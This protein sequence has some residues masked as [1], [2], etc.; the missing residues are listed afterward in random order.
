MELGRQLPPAAQD[1]FLFSI[2]ID[3]LQS[4]NEIEGVKSTRQEIAASAKKV[5]ASNHSHPQVNNTRMGSMIQSYFQLTEHTLSVP[6][7]VE[8]FRTIYDYITK[9]EIEASDLPDGEIFIQEAAVVRSTTG[10]VLHHGV[11]SEQ[12]IIVQMARLLA[13]LNSDHLPSLVKLAIGHYYFG[14]IHPFYDG[15]VTLRYNQNVA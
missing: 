2:L 3:E 15:N 10:A 6:D 12:K 8:D 14:Y 9:G 4:T 11:H 1:D 5:K 13:F 7:K